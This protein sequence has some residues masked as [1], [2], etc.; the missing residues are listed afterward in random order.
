MRRAALILLV[1]GLVLAATAQASPATDVAS[2]LLK[3]AQVGSGYAVRKSAGWN[4]VQGQVTLDLCG[5]QFASESL[6]VAREQVAY[7]AAGK[8]PLLSNEVVAY[9]NGGA[10]K[11]LTEVRNA[12]ATCPSGWTSSPLQAIAREKSTISVLHPAGLLPGSYAFVQHLSVQERNSSKIEEV[13]SVVVFQQRNGVLSAV[14]SAS[15]S[16]KSLALRAAAQAK[17]NLLKL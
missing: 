17:S 12:V 16:S 9:R 4:K 2:V 10:V 3:P 11:A 14:Y 15:L 1:L 13:T 7:Q 8:Q 5:K 6:R